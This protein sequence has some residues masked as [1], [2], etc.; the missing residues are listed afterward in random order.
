MYAYIQSN[1]MYHSMILSAMNL[2]EKTMKF[3]ILETKV[4]KVKT[5]DDYKCTK[6]NLDLEKMNVVEKIYLH[7]QTKE[8]IYSDLL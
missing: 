8:V 4:K 5:I 3:F 6:I 1:H 2:E 7:R